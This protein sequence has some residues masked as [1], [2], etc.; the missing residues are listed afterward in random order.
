MYS[1]AS[2]IENHDMPKKQT[3]PPKQYADNS[4]PRKFRPTL[5]DRTYNALRD[6]ID[7]R[8]QTL[9][10]IAVGADVTLGWLQM[11]SKDEIP[12][13]AVSRIEKL[14]KFLTGATL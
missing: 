3:W 9:R 11:F 8:K 2:L 1:P 10:E 5:R 6:T 14:Y 13:P 4:K 7:A 12:D